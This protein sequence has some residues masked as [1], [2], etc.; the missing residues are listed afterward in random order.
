MQP[1]MKFRTFR[2]IPLPDKQSKNVKLKYYFLLKTFL[3]IFESS[4]PRMLLKDKNPVHCN[5]SL[6]EKWTNQVA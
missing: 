5:D 3:R 1:T 6:R 4:K 2:T